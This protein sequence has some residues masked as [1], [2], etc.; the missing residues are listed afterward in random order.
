MTETQF[1]VWDIVRRTQERYGCAG[2]HEIICIAYRDGL[3]VPN[4]IFKSTDLIRPVL[5]EM[6]AA[7]ILKLIPGSGHAYTTDI[8]LLT[9]LSMRMSA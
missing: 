7:G 8:D 4:D 9:A 2:R 5:T 6:V 1:Q 3:D